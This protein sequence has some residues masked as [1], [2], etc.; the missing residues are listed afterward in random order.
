LRKTQTKEEKVKK[1]YFAL[2]SVIAAGTL[3]LEYFLRQIF[4]HCHKLFSMLI[5][6]IEVI[7]VVFNLSVLMYGVFIDEHQCFIDEIDLKVNKNKNST[8]ETIN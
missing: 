8:N 4:L 6:M 3:A 7:I 2:C 1:K 5:L